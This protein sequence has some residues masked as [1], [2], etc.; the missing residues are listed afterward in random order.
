[1]VE[2]A[3]LLGALILAAG[4]TAQ[5]PPAQ[6][7]YQPQQ[8]QPQYGY[9]QPAQQPQYGYPQQQP[10]PQY[11]YPPPQGYPPPPVAPAPAPQ[12]SAVPFPWW[13]QGGALPIPNLGTFPGLPGVAPVPAPVPAPAP[14]SPVASGGAAQDCVDSINRYRASLRLAP[15]SRWVEA[16]PCASGQ[17]QSD[18][19]SGRA[20]G[21]FGRCQEMAQNVC[22]GWRGPAEQVTGPC[23]QSMWNE[24]PG[25]DYAAHG[26]YLNMANARYTRVACG[27]HTK[28]DGQVWAVQDFQ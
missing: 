11:G 15:L 6:Y 13:P 27:Y 5:E 3:R 4:C 12:P 17:A 8:Q 24:G 28:P 2:R 14:V 16:E 22:P 9:Q 7:G 19:Q 10:P 23:L 25:A 21:S 26:H 20:H 1:M 18:S